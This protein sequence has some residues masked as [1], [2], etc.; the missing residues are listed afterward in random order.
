[1]DY[2]RTLQQGIRDSEVLEKEK[3]EKKKKSEEMKKKKV[4]NR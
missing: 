4:K 2:S 1:M 3:A